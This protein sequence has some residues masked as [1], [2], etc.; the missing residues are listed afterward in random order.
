MSSQY[1]GE[2]TTVIENKAPLPAD[3]SA[4][5]KIHNEETGLPQQWFESTSMVE[6]YTVMMKNRF[7]ETQIAITRAGSAGRNVLH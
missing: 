1:H 3:G 7:I 4:R 6:K 5:P 2:Q